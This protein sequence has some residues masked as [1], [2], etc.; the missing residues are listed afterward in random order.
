M[1][2]YIVTDGKKYFAGNKN[3]SGHPECARFYKSPVSAGNAAA[4]L[5]GRY[6]TNWYPVSVNVKAKNVRKI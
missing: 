1:K 6:H 2:L 5:R 4:A 3:V